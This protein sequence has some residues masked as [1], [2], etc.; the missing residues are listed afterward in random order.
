MS[1]REAFEQAQAEGATAP[2]KT[3]LANIDKQLANFSG[4]LDRLISAYLEKTA[5]GEAHG[6]GAISLVLSPQ[7]LMG[8]KWGAVE[9][10]DA[11]ELADAAPEILSLP[12]FREAL[13]YC[14]SRE[15]DIAFRVEIYPVAADF[16]G[17]EPCVSLVADLTK[18]FAESCI[19][20][21]NL[22]KANKL[23]E[24][25]APLPAA[26]QPAPETIPVTKGKLSWLSLKN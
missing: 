23:S 24:I 7:S 2:V 1:L 26:P 20:S 15:R 13:E 11:A 14:A 19:C 16:A 8:D 4:A 22:D 21:Y 18:S 9:T 5:A 12:G 10:P 3:A 17:V 6:D 25:P